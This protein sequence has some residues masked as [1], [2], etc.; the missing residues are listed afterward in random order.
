MKVFISWSGARSRI[1]AEALRSWLPDIINAVEPFV[2]ELDIDKGAVGTEVI[3]RQLKDSAFGIVCLTRDNQT[4]PWINYEAGALS[5]TV[6]DDDARVATVLIDIDGPAGVTGPLSAFQAT[7]LH[8]REAI[9]QL[10]ASIAKTAGDGRS[11]EKLD[12]LVD[13]LWDSLAS[14]VTQEILDASGEASAVPTRQP[15][16]MFAEILTLVRQLSQDLSR[17]NKLPSRQS[18]QN[19]VYGYTAIITRMSDTAEA[20]GYSLLRVTLDEAGGALV[21]LNGDPK[22]I[23]SDLFDDLQSA[24]SEVDLKLL[25]VT[26]EKPPWRSRVPPPPRE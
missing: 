21:T 20:Y 26:V 22:P 15:E 8:H 16:D 14:Q 24:A 5:K 18:I 9:K 13:R 4:R 1:V 19:G 11:R 17:S 3:G 2:S 6:G 10:V 12:R 25:N 23:S 7:Q